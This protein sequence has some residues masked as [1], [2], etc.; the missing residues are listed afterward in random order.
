MTLAV[1]HE[2]TV[3]GLA[4]ASLYKSGVEDDEKVLSVL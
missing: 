2:G 1:L 4:A 3:H